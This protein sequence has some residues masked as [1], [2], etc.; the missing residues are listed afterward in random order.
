MRARIQPSSWIIIYAVCISWPR[1]KTISPFNL[2][3]ARNVYVGDVLLYFRCQN[4]GQ[5]R[6]R[7]FSSFDCNA[8]NFTSVVPSTRLAGILIGR[9]VIRHYGLPVWNWNGFTAKT[10]WKY[11]NS[12][13]NLEVTRARL[14]RSKIRVRSVVSECTL[15]MTTTMICVRTTAKPSR[16]ICLSATIGEHAKPSSGI[17]EFRV[18]KWSSLKL[19]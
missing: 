8:T 10:V 13:R 12:P 7:R 11:Q 3:C 18:W 16:N 5:N 15:E 14:N 1:F 19:S 9:R 4:L 6:C 17:N 2:S